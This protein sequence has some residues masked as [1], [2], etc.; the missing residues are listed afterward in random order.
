[1]TIFRICFVVEIVVEIVVI[2]FFV[3][4]EQNVFVFD[5]VFE[6]V[7]GEFFGIDEEVDFFHFVDEAFEDFFS[8]V[9]FVDVEAIFEDFVVDLEGGIHLQESEFD[10]VEAI[11]KEVLIEFEDSVSFEEIF[12]IVF[13]AFLVVFAKTPAGIFL[14]DRNFQIVLFFELLRQKRCD[15]RVD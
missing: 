7:L 9:F 8:V 6:V 2:V 3:V 4:F 14:T 12:Q 10:D 15:V 5:F 1:M 11:V 13:F